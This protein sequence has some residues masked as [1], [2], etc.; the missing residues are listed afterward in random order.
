MWERSEDSCMDTSL[1]SSKLNPVSIAEVLGEPGENPESSLELVEPR[2]TV[3]L[4]Q[5]TLEDLLIETPFRS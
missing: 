1:L 4:L 3:I 5:G 2:S